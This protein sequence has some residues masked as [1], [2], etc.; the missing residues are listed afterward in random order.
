MN[1]SG[2]KKDFD[3][4]YV[5][6][7]GTTW[8]KPINAGPNINSNKNE[9]YTCIT[10]DGTIYFSSN[11]KAIQTGKDD[12]DVFMA[13]PDKGGFKKA[14]RV[15]SPVNTESYE[16]D[17]FVAPDGSYLII[18]SDRTGGYGAGDLYICFRKPDGSWSQAKNMG[19]EINEDRFQYCPIVT[20]DGKYLLFTSKDNIRW[21]DASVIDRFR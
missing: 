9:Y 21:I 1:G 2:P 7:N 14:M 18:C 11:V 15:D 16:G 6:R 20:P 13:R 3:I 5:E 10:A 17:V 4:W 8:S 19:K 12:Y